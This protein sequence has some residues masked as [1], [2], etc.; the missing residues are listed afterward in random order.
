M[1]EFV[2]P[3]LPGVFLEWIESTG[4]Q[5]LIVDNQLSTDEI[6]EIDVNIKSCSS[7]SGAAGL[8][9]Y[10]ENNVSKINMTTHTNDSG[11]VGNSAASDR[12]VNF[13]KVYI[14][15]RTFFKI[16][17][18]K[19]YVDDYEVAIPY[20]VGTVVI[21]DN[22]LL[23]RIQATTSSSSIFPI[24]AKLY[25]FKKYNDTKSQH[26]LPFLHQDGRIGMWDTVGNKFYPNMGTGEFIA[27]PVVDDEFWELEYIESTGTQYINTLVKACDL[28]TVDFK[29]EI[30][31]KDTIGWYFGS[32]TGYSNNAFCLATG[33]GATRIQYGSSAGA[34]L[35]VDTLSEV[36]GQFNF[37]TDNLQL[38]INNG[39][40]TDNVIP[41]NPLK[42]DGNHVCL[43]AMMAGG[44]VDSRM[45]PIRVSHYISTQKD[46]VSQHLIPVQKKI[47]GEVCMYDLVSK[48]FFSNAGT[49]EFIA[50]PRKG[51]GFK[52]TG[53]LADDTT[54]NEILQT[55]TEVK[56]WI[57]ARKTTL[58]T[59]KI[60]DSTVRDE[61]RFK[62]CTSLFS[63]YTS[64]IEADLEDFDVSNV[65]TLHSMFYG[66]NKLVNLNVAN[67]DTSKVD[68]MFALFYNCQ[69]L[70]AIDVSRWNTRGVI[71]MQSIFNGCSNL[72]SIDVSKW[73]TSTAT[74]M[75]SMFQSC[76]KLTTIDTSNFTSEKLVTIQSMFYSCKLL[77]KIDLSSMNIHTGINLNNAFNDCTLV[78][79]AYGKDEESCNLLNTSSGKPKNVN[80]IV[81]Q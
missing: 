14:G 70:T 22:P 23:A 41:T 40:L 25:S 10:N 13:G 57:V 79:E 66:C 49:G 32:R 52:L 6:Y 36:K 39:E 46:G 2:T 17:K 16:D 18:D 8:F 26:L 61:F 4:T 31:Q 5:Y 9:G 67:W 47:S 3:Q 58:K 43:F 81:K 11:W 24:M 29:F 69:S 34:Q 60:D 63:G 78:S 42:D 19:L 68:N 74:N 59:I 30:I 53:T 44:V 80:F 55:E 37:D 1:E 27:G 50:G 28:A 77:T 21:K 45:V 54:F 15:E 56:A 38:D 20:S 7:S 73:N 71:N 62:N 72:T 35:R 33:E 48:K 76:S 51:N 12:F 65:T 64:L 75:L